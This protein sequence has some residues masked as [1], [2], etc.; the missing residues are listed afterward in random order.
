M[1]TATLGRFNPG[2]EGPILQKAELAPRP[3][4]CGNFAPNPEPVFYPRNL[5]L[6]AS[7]YT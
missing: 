7:R 5:H 1:V 4:V 3:N 6:V 2:K